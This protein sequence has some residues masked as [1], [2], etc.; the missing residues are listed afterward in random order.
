MLDEPDVG[1]NRTFS[2]RAELL[3][4]KLTE[5]IMSGRL[6]PGTRLDEQEIARR[7]GV[8][9]TPVREA[10]RH[11]VATGL[12]DSQPHQGAS[13]AMVGSDR[14]T[15]FLDAAT[16]LEATCTRLAAMRMDS[17]ERARLV[18]IHGE[19]RQ[20]LFDE[21]ARYAELNHRFHEAIYLGSHSEVLVE[22]VRNLM[23][24][25]GHV[26]RVRLTLMQGA[27]ESFAEHDRIVTAI[28]SGD[29]IAA[30]VAMRAHMSSSALMIERLHGNA[31]VNIH[32]ESTTSPAKME[33]AA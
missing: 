23:F 32:R 15:A 25:M 26:Y 12:V 8:S 16:E 28:L 11:L 21:P 31:L 24:R 2:T 1:S 4:E 27:R 14:L 22:M 5:E 13:V 3:R 9:R 29:A 10:M 17:A 18:E 7:F 6:V 30:E 33:G 20:V 19:V